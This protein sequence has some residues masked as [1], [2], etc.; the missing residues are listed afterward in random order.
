MIID[1]NDDCSDSSNFIALRVGIGYEILA[2]VTISNG[3]KLLKMSPIV[4]TCLSR[5]MLKFYDIVTI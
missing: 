1:Y 4:W 3:I 5:I 2:Q